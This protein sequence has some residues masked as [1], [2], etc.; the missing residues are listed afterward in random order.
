MFAPSTS[1]NTMDIMKMI[2]I[3]TLQLNPLRMAL[4]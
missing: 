3:F 2:P 1:F 4:I